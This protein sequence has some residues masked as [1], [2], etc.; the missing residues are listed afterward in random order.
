MWE[1]EPNYERI[2]RIKMMKINVFEYDNYRTYLRDFYNQSKALNPNFSYRYFARISGISSPSF[3]KHIID[4]DRNLTEAT[5]DKFAKALKFTKQE[6]SYFKA[7]VFLN[8]SQTTEEREKHAQELSRHRLFLKFQSLSAAQMNYYENWYYVAIR[9]MVTLKSFS[10][11]P[12]SIA[13]ALK[14]SITASEAKKALEELLRMGLL[15][16]DDQGQLVQSETLVTTGHEVTSAFVSRFHKEMMGKAAESI[17]RYPKPQREISS[18]TFAV[19]RETF[20]IIKEKVQKFRQEM[21]ELAAQD[22]H[23]DFV[24]QLNLQL[25]PLSDPD[26]EGA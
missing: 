1:R 6:T 3:L 25:F 18:G 17:D 24:C 11:D 8:Q 21:Q 4:G 13:Q 14:P 5:V 23:H 9:E 7:L 16:F 10:A 26:E 2:Q 20:Q 15:K 19:S 12:Q 22:S